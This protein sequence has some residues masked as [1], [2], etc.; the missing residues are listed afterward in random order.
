V[1]LAKH[2]ALLGGALL[3][4]EASQKVS[5]PELFVVALQVGGEAICV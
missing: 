1:T 3:G 5:K 4:R 2:A